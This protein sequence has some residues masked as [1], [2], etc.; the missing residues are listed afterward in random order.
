MFKVKKKSKYSNTKTNGYD[1]KK[2]YNRSVVL[3]MLE[4]KGLVSDLKEQVPFVIAPA[5]YVKNFK[6]KDTCVLRDVKYIAD[7]VYTEKEKT[8]VEDCKGF[9][10]AQY[11][12]KKNLMK[13]ILGIEI[14]ET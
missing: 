2:E 6:G 12:K 13:R 3:K 10:T 5:Y 11:T 8:I 9:R 1:S 14:L 7:F 4:K